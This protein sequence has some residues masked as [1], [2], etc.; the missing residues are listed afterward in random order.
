MHTHLYKAGGAWKTSDGIEY[1]VK[2]FDRLGGRA[3]IKTGEWYKSL[4]DALAIEAES[5][6]ISEYGS[7][8]EKELRANIKALGGKAAGRSSIKRLEAQL[9]ELENGDDNEG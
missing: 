4:E 9:E 5:E 3:A 1:T 2:A 6:V 8:H 7:E